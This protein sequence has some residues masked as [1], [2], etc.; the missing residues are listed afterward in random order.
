MPTKLWKLN[1]VAILNPSPDLDDS[2][3]HLLLVTM[4]GN[5]NM[6]NS[7][8]VMDANRSSDDPAPNL[9]LILAEDL[10]SSSL[11]RSLDLGM[12]GGR[13]M[14]IHINPAGDQNLSSLRRLSLD[15]G[16]D[17]DPNL[18]S[19]RLLNLNLGMAGDPNMANKSPSTDLSMAGNQ[20]TENMDPNMGGDPATGN[21][22]LN[23]DLS[24]AERQSMKEV[25]PNMEPDTDGGLRASMDR[26]MEV[27]QRLNTG[28]GMRGNQVMVDPRKRKKDIGSQVMVDPRNRKKDI[29]SQVMV[30]PRN[31]KKDIGSQVMV[32][33]RKRKKDIGSQ[34]MVDR[35]KKDMAAR[36]I[37]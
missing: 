33:P 19:L 22:N 29:G 21:P 8:L 10:N 36:N 3:L 4:E 30:D 2:N 35:R 23:T 17:G 25:D 9:N 1:T 7:N 24:L 34:V 11:L 13:H 18:S 32:D 28:P 31:R 37:L 14:S 12:A 27:G 20:S 16:I 6:S 15:L 5:L 26:A